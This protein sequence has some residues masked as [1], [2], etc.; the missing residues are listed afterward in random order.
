MVR[1][2][3]PGQRPST[4][5]RSGMLGAG[6]ANSA[7][8]PACSPRRQR[9][10]SIYARVTTAARSRPLE[11]ASIPARLRKRKPPP[12]VRGSDSCSS[13]PLEARELRQQLQR[14]Q[15]NQA[16]DGQMNQHGMKAPKEE[17]RRRRNAAPAKRPFSIMPPADLS[18]DG[19][20]IPAYTSY[21]GWGHTPHKQLNV[22]DM[23]LNL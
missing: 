10:Q 3:A 8:R 16:P 9:S 17:T 13:D 2:S 23:I 1:T 12:P 4:A 7:A 19:N 20:K 6:L 18:I 15:Q 14:A 22:N 11:R 5:A 21:Y